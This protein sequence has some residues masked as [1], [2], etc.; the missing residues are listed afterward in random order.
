MGILWA[1]TGTIGCIVLSS[2]SHTL[3]VQIATY[4]GGPTNKGCQSS[5]NLHHSKKLQYEI[6]VSIENPYS[7]VTLKVIESDTVETRSHITMPRHKCIQSEYNY[8][9]E[10]NDIAEHYKLSQQ[11]LP[12]ACAVFQ[13]YTMYSIH[14]E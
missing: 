7:T 3:R 13:N 9:T 12:L 14:S 4:G 5:L 2:C 8:D 11:L 6:N 10:C 1:H